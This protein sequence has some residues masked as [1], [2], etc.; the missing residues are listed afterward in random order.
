MDAATFR[1]EF[2][3]EV[4]ADLVALVDVTAGGDVDR[5]LSEGLRRLGWLLE[6]TASLTWNAGATSV[7]LPADYYKVSDVVPATGT[8][9]PAYRVFGTVIRFLDPDGAE[10][11]GEATLYYHARHADIDD[12]N[13]STLPDEGNRALQAFLLYRFWKKLATN[14]SDYRRYA[15]IAG[16]NAVDIDELTAMADRALD[17]FLSLQ[18]A[19][20][21]Q[22]PVTFFGD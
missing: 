15:T 3:D 18:G 20:P 11:D 14:R 19:L 21:L 22:E 1:S 10:A 2:S 6:Q 5:W 17:D 13:P 4:G 9:L 16:Q 7:A 8:R 12:A